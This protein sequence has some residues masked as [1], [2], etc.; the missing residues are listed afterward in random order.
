MKPAEGIYA[1]DGAEDLYDDDREKCGLVRYYG[2]E[3]VARVKGVNSIV[4]LLHTL[5]ENCEV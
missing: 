5:R 4:D 1:G 3:A 2:A